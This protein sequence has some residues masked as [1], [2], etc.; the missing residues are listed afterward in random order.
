[1]KKSFEP[2][3]DIK[4]EMDLSER[5]RVNRIRGK[6]LVEKG[7]LSN[8]E[9]QANLNKILVEEAERRKILDI[10]KQESST[11]SKIS[12]ILNLEPKNV[13]IHLIAL[14]KNRKVKIVG[15]EEEEYIYKLI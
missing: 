1:M 11:V 8:D 6:I 10:L 13:V 14:I 7:I 12:Q 2:K 5:L 9:Y 15:E 4:E 3:Y